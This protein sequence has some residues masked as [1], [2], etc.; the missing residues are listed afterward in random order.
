MGIHFFKRSF[1]CFLT[2]SAFCMFGNS[3]VVAAPAA[4]QLVSPVPFQS[5]KLPATLPGQ[6][7]PVGRVKIGTTTNSAIIQNG[8]VMSPSGTNSGDYQMSFRARALPNAE[9]GVQIWAG[10]RCRDRDSQYVFALRGGINREIYIARYAPDGNA[11]FLG[12]AP[13]DFIPQANQWYR[14]R[15]AVVGNRIQIFLNDEQLPRLNAVDKTP[16][17]QTGGVTLGGGWLPTEY[18]D[19]KVEPLVGAQLSTFNAVGDKVWETPT[20]N[21]EAMRAKQREQYRPVTIGDIKTPRAEFSLDG[22][23]LF[24]PEQDLKANGQPI[25]S[26]TADSNWH[27]MPVPGFWKPAHAWL[28]GETTFHDLKGPARSKG[29]A[30]E[31][32]IEEFE[33]LDSL[34]FD[35]NK[36]QSGWYRQYVDLPANIAGK[37]LVLNFDAVAK[38]S[39]VWVNGTRVGDHTGMFGPLTC[40]ITSAVKPG[41]NVIAVHCIGRQN[42]AVNDNKVEGVAVT[43]EVTTAMLRSLPHG[44]FPDDVGGIWQPVKLLVTSPVAVEDVQVVPG[45]QSASFNLHVANKSS[46]NEL[47]NVRYRITDAKD[48]KLL[49]DSPQVTPL[50]I[51]ASA[52]QEI[53]LR[54]PALSPKLWTPDNPNLYKLTVSLSVGNQNVDSYDVQFG[55]RTFGVKGEQLLLNGKPYWLRGGNHFPNTIRPN[56]T[57]LARRFT[58]LAHDGNVRVTRSHTVPFTQT[59]LEAADEI[60]MGVSYEGTWPWL[61]LQGAPPTPELLKVWK[62]E[63]SA[64]IKKYRNHPSIL[65][66]TVNN[67]S[68]FP[69]LEG[70]P[71]ML[72]RKWAVLDDMIR[73]MREIDPTRP[74]VAD[75]SYTRAQAKRG[76]DTVVKPNG[77]DDGDIDDNHSYYGWYNPSPFNLYDGQVFARSAAPGRPLISQEMSSGYPRNDGHPTR[78]YLF[79][80]ATAQSFVGQDAYEN[81]DPAIFMSRQAFITKELAEVF[82]RANRANTAGIM[83]FSYLTWFTN[84]WKADS[85][86]PKVTYYAL[87]TALQPVLVSAELYGRHF[88]A[89]QSLTPRVCIVN[90]AESGLALPPSQLIWQIRDGIKILATGQ[91]AVAAVP[92][93]SNLWVNA[94]IALPPSLPSPRVDV[95]L[96]LKLQVAGR[97][98]SENQYD[99]TLT[100]REWSGN[101]TQIAVFD[102]TGSLKTALQGR[103]VRSI[104]SLNG[105]DSKTPI[106]VG[107]LDGVVNNATAVT[108]FTDFFKAGG[109]ALFLQPGQNLVKLFPDQI[110]K[111]QSAQGEMVTMNVPESPIFDGIATLDMAWFDAGTAKVPYAAS[112]RYQIDS[113]RQDVMALAQQ[114]DIHAYLKLPQEVVNVSGSTIVEIRVGNGRVLASEMRLDATSDPI[115]ARLLTNL[116]RSLQSSQ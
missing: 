23:W 11:V 61:M 67:E 47:V 81:A 66:W 99:I 70:D 4:P 19:L 45:L 113:S 79:Q 75:S 57:A 84:V 92:Y 89:G 97:T 52:Q 17:W 15:A 40:D 14:F 114:M 111:Y 90:D 86:Q 50:Q 24:M 64:L 96:V 98:L 3:A 18:A 54:T 33:Q 110:K 71:A 82:R 59:W 55:F 103:S 88:F 12:Y 39:E 27:I 63:Y 25:E 9:G 32:T 56:D 77:F 58:Q 80:H 10:L 100:T 28:H 13:L 37:R 34:T 42:G 20:V 112:G 7:K 29:I 41:R 16:L 69:V 78:S 60:G 51:N 62:D 5:I 104:D 93:Y 65:L 43:V 85:I 91:Q 83:H 44:M 36:T 6:W 1:A 2:A 30:D 48:G 22:N 101:T 49:F 68:K 53:T 46:K 106:I 38:I 102:P 95:Q 26:N 35:W 74:I 116:I 105:L 72:K 108:Q 107:N 115:S 94:N 73:T 76:Y 21:K 109:R 8:F 87:K 31:L